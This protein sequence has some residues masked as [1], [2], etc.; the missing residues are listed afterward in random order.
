MSDHSIELKE[1]QEKFRRQFAQ[2]EN[3]D[4]LLDLFQNLKDI[5]VE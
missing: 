2:T 4:H 5:E 3:S 1:L